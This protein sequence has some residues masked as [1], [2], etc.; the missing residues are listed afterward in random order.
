MGIGQEELGTD[1]EEYERWCLNLKD[2]QSWRKAKD[3]G[4][5]NYFSLD[6]VRL[7]PLP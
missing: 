5:L 1:Q 2:P 4:K 3:K 7:S 6:S